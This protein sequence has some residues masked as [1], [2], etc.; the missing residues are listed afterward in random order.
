MNGKTRHMK[1]LSSP[2][3]RRTAC[4]RRTRC[5]RCSGFVPEQPVQNVLLVGAERPDEFA[6]AIRLTCR[7]HR[8]MVIN[9]RETSS[10]SAF[11]RA[12]GRFVRARIEQ[13]PPGCCRFDI[14]CENYPYPGGQHYVPPRP[15]AFAR[16]L[17]LA[18]GGRWT[19]FTESARFATLLK[20]AVDYDHA[21]RGRFAVAVDSL[22]PGEAPPSNYPPVSTRYRLIFQ[23]LR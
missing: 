9:P 16:L 5:Q 8:V 7:G 15:F 4:A 2:S 21:A 6:D 11:R 3:G 13:L 20:A 10:A 22:G 17:R 12:G 19:L 14:I 1:Q 18:P 23:R